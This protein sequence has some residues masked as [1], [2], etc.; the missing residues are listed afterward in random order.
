[1]DY[2]NNYEVIQKLCSELEKYVRISSSDEDDREEICLKI[3]AQFLVYSHELLDDGTCLINKDDLVERAG[4]IV[5]M[6][7]DAKVD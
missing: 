1:M 2:K 5:C 6:V 4:A 3:A 7:I